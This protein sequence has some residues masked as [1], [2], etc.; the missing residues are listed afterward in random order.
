MPQL[1]QLETQSA[2][3]ILSLSLAAA[4][5]LAGGLLPAE[6]AARRR[7]GHSLTDIGENPGASAAWRL[8]G[9]KVGI[10]V[11]GFDLL[12]GAIPFLLAQYAL[13]L[14]GLWLVLPSVAPVIGHNWP[15]RRAGKGGHGLG[16][17]GGV[18]LTAGFPV[19]VYSALVGAVPAALVFRKKWGVAIAAVA[20]PLGIFLMIRRDYAPDVIAVV[21]CVTAIMGVRLWM[22]KRTDASSG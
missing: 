3:I 7:L 17:G 16:P 11:V 10:A 6:W 9:A 18:L 13:R 1:S 19:M 2:Q 15:F 22:G 14:Q 21:V 12:K 5:Y 4:A 20:I 8:M